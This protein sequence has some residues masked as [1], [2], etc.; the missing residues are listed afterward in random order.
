M[1]QTFGLRNKSLLLSHDYIFVQLFLFVFSTKN[2]MRSRFI[3]HY[4]LAQ[5]KGNNV[6]CKRAITVIFRTVVLNCKF[7]SISYFLHL[8]L[9]PLRALLLGAGTSFIVMFFYHNLYN[10]YLLTNKLTYL[11]QKKNF[12]PEGTNEL[13]LWRYIKSPSWIPYNWFICTTWYKLLSL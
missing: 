11:R 12:I 13:V 4:F 7:Q 8:S 3:T 5:G 6:C 1:L 2:M 10:F 9:I